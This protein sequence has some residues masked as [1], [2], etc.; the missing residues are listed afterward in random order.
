MLAAR[1]QVVSAAIDARKSRQSGALRDP[2]QERDAIARGRATAAGL[3]LPSTLAE[4]QLTLRMRRSLGIATAG[5]GH[6]YLPHGTGHRRRR[7][8]RRLVR[9][10]AAVAGLCGAD[11]RSRPAPRDLAELPHTSDWTA[12]SLDAAVIAVAAPLRRAVDVLRALIP[13]RP[14]G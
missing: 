6:R 13:R 9:A 5:A 10:V 3:G 4:D 2:L 1:R 8:H 11:C 14:Q 7:P 12:S